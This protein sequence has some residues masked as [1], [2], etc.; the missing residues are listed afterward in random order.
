MTDAF[1]KNSS[2]RIFFLKGH[3][4]PAVCISN[5]SKE[6]SLLFSPKV[7]HYLVQETR[8]HKYPLAFRIIFLVQWN[9]FPAF[10]HSTVIFLPPSFRQRCSDWKD[11]V[12]LFLYLDITMH[13]QY[14]CGSTITKVNIHFGKEFLNSSVKA[15]FLNLSDDV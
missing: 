12:E 13:S 5:S 7:F 4:D 1:Q 8:Y 11:Y 2:Q 6:K 3:R 10:S 15:S 9:R 14:L